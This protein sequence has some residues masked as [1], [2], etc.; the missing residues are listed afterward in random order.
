MA[1]ARGLPLVPPTTADHDAFLA[2]AT[3]SG[4][5]SSP[6]HGRRNLPSPTAASKAASPCMAAA[7]ATTLPPFLS[8]S[9]PLPEIAAKTVAKSGLHHRRHRAALPL[10]CA[11]VR[12]GLLPS[13]AAASS[14]PSSLSSSLMGGGAAPSPPYSHALFWKNGAWVQM[15]PLPPCLVLSFFLSYF[16]I[17][18][19]FVSFV[20]FI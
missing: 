12:R 15:N 3:V 19:L 5:A 8:H 6:P 20:Y 18:L 17:F 11:P 16:F 2:T 10:P 1:A 13:M 7:A 9:V 14:S 4:L